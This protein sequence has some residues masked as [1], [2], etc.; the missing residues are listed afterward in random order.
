MADFLLTDALAGDD[1]IRV[2]PS[3]RSK[4]GKDWTRKTS[5]FFLNNFP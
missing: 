1:G 2:T 3:L 4:K 5:F